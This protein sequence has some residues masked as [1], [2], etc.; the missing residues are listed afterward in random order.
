MRALL[1]STIAVVSIVSQLAWA[2]ENGE[3]NRGAPGIKPISGTWLNLFNQDVRN[4]YTNPAGVDITAP[5][6]WRCKIREMSEMGVKYLVFM[7]VAN[8]GKA[9]YES[10]FMPA[11]YPAGRESPVEAI[12][13]AADEN[14]MKVFLST[15]WAVNQDDDMEKPEIRGLH[16]KI[17]RE[18]AAKFARHPSFFGWYFPCEFSAAPWIPDAAIEGVNTLAAEARKLTPGAKTMI[19]PWVVTKVV[20]K[21][22]FQL[23]TEFSYIGQLKKLNVDIIAYQ[24]GVG[25]AL[26]TGPQSK[27]IYGKLRD[28]HNL[29]PHLAMWA[30]VETFTWDG[31]KNER[32][33]P[34]VPAAFPR[35][36]SQLA[37]VSPYV[38]E[39]ISFIVQGMLDKPGS[40]MPLGEAVYSS[41][42]AGD[43]LDFLAGTGRWPLLAASCTGT[44]SHEAV[45]KAVTLTAPPAPKYGKGNLTDGAFGVEDKTAAEWLGF[46]RRDM[47]A[48][49]DLGQTTR[50]K[51]LAARFL[52]RSA[53]GIALPTRVDFAVSGNGRDFAAA[54]SVTPETWPHNEHDAWIDMAVAD[55]LNLR[56]RYVRVRAV[57]AGQWLFVDE[58]LVNPTVK[59]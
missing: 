27:R 43:Y 58:L 15:G 46:E 55:R 10:D 39:T 50:I 18:C 14:G 13:K 22:Y 21:D 29:V 36:L 51:T 24:D 54:A 53:A 38:D 8:E 19:S 5:A 32:D 35:V 56:G 2:G 6:L 37:I 47:E 31:E 40:P 48:I 20:A 17:M 33:S 11:A 57:N 52:Q 25:S 23:K 42:M 16:L 30:N 7:A 4:K 41:K 28:V 59:K 34:L 1:A 45:G 9:M 49:I 3:P 12:M 44:L 26:A